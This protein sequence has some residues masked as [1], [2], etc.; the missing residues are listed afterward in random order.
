M[1]TN[2]KTRID[3]VLV[4]QCAIEGNFWYQVFRRL[5]DIIIFTLAS[6]NLAFRGHREVREEVDIVGCGNFLLFN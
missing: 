3:K 6:E 5:V 2:E 1:Y 4:K